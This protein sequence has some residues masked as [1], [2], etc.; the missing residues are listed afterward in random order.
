[1]KKINIFSHIL[2][3]KYKEA[4]LNTAPTSLDI[5]SNITA[6]PTVFDLERRFKIMDKFE[7]LVEML[8]IAAPGVGEVAEPKTAMDLARIAND[9]LAELIARYPD[10]F[11]GGIACLPLN[12]IDAALHE[13]DRAILDL[14][15]GGIE[16]HTP[17]NDNPIDSPEFLPFYEKMAKYDLPIWLHPRRAQTYP[18]YRAEDKSKYRIFSVFGWPYETTVAMA[19]LVF[20]GILDKYPNLKIITHHCGGMVPYFRERVRGSYERIFHDIGDNLT[21]GI[22]RPHMDYFKMFY[23]DTA[24]NGNTSALM[25]A[26]DFYGADHLLFGTDMPFD[27]EYGERNLRQIIEAIEGMDISNLEKQKIFESNAKKLLR[28]SA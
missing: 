7:G 20:S 6:T 12:N 21:Q 24:I 10:R 18:D 14:K 15:L 28:L 19:R 3:P 16:I 23:C 13:V 9:G 26:Y 11:I 27:T 1:M 4:L 25:C 2:P 5:M 17:A 8:S 22:H